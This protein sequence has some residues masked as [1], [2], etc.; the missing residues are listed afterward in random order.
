MTASENWLRTC[1]SLVGVMFT[2]INISHPI[3]TESYHDDHFSCGT[4]IKCSLGYSPKVCPLEV[5]CEYKVISEKITHIED[6]SRLDELPVGAEFR[7]VNGS[8][9]GQIVMHNGKRCIHILEYPDAEPTSYDRVRDLYIT[10][11]KVPD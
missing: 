9:T 5:P 4:D 6:S 1:R 7:V 2:S 8:W 11:I 10:N 3:H